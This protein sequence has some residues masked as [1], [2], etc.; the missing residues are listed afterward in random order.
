MRW[1]CGA[2]GGPAAPSQALRDLVITDCDRLPISDL[3]RR[4]GCLLLNGDAAFA[5]QFH[6]GAFARFGE[7]A[8]QIV[9]D[10]LKAVVTASSRYEPRISRTYQDMATHY[11]TA[12]LPARARKLRD[13]AKS[14]PPGLIQGSKSPS[15]S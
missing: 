10:K 13:E 1:S 2:E 3:D 15:R 5:S 9:S 4:P 14:L 12:I 8:R 6:V 7:V 11:G